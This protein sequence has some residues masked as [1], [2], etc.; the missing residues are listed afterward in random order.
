MVR[1]FTG[2]TLMEVLIASLIFSSIILLSVYALEQGIRQYKGILE[3]GFN[4]W[5]KARIFWL[6]RSLSSAIDYYVYDERK[7]FWYPFFKG[8]VDMVAY[9]SLAPFSHNTPVLAILKKEE[10]DGKFELVYYELPVYTYN[11]KDLEEILVFES[12]QRGI[13]FTFFEGLESLEFKY[14]GYDR[15]RH[16]NDWFS[17][18]DGSRFL[19]LPLSLKIEYN[20]GDKKNFFYFP[21]NVQNFRKAYY[22]EFYQK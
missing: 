13:K 11:L 6:S 14:Y 20:Q 2:Y 10:K 19:Q 22:N 9:I 21:L 8:R 16:F 1:K 18:F 12:Y 5:E 15:F 4:F 7:K 3:R 17:E